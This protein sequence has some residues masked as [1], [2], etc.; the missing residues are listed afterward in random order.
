MPSGTPF[1]L[2]MYDTDGVTLIDADI[3]AENGGITIE[4]NN[5]PALSQLN[6]EGTE[7]YNLVEL[8][9]NNGL[10]FDQERVT[11]FI[12]AGGAAVGHA[13]SSFLLCNG[14]G[15][16]VE[17][18]DFGVD[19]KVLF[20]DFQNNLQFGCLDDAIGSELGDIFFNVQSNQQ[21]RFQQNLSPV[22]YIQN[23]RLCVPA[24]GS[25]GPGNL[26][27]STENA[28]P[29]SLGGTLYDITSTTSTTDTNGTFDTLN[30]F[31]IAGSVFQNKG[32]KLRGR[33][34][35]SFVGSPT[36][37][38]E[39][40]L[41][42]GGSTIFDTGSLTTSSNCRGILDFTIMM[43]SSSSV[44]YEVS[45]VCPGL[46]SA[47]G[48]S[49]GTVTG[50]TLTGVNT[51][52]LAAAASGT[53]AA[54]GDISSLAP[55]AIEWLP[56]AINYASPLNLAPLVWIKADGLSYQN[57]NRTSQCTSD[58]QAVDLMIDYSLNGLHEWQ[59]YPSGSFSPT[60]E[61]NVQNSLPG[62]L[63]NGSSQFLLQ[64]FNGDALNFS[65][66]PQP[67]S[68]YLV[69]KVLSEPTGGK[70]NLIGT[71]PNGPDGLIYDFLF[72]D[73]FL[74][75]GTSLVGPSMSQN[76]TYTFQGLFNGG[77]S[78]C[79]LNG[80]GKTTGN[81]GTDEMTC[82]VIGQGGNIPAGSGGTQFTNMYL[83]EV[84]VFDRELSSG[85]ESTV[86]SYLRTKWGHY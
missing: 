45:I 3:S 68:I 83:F 86:L 67:Y 19:M 8:N 84:L 32:D 35:V 47:V 49:V 43:L 13:N 6:S 61:T 69:A 64:L 46:S 29:A 40:T 76:T 72:G 25:L 14:A 53:G 10:H 5:I 26:T 23:N 7:N 79:S 22:G 16:Y 70:G 24:G 73:Y 31:A 51:L 17:S 52:A 12:A 33:I 65:S 28:V 44:G 57:T 18:W 39:I 21:F 58:G 20:S 37:H 38:R 48:P 27:S 66:V 41:A 34:P 4:S 63:F 2:V 55:G 56:A 36:A 71:N 59:I 75:A 78:T 62:I 81:A 77:S 9:T 85:D 11:P 82:L 80:G 54:S 74:Q 15:L 1:D 50:L 42:F 30:S 60:Y